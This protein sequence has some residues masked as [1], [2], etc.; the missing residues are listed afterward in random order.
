MKYVAAL[1]ES[2][3]GNIDVL[4]TSCKEANIA[5]R[6]ILGS[7]E[8]SSLRLVEIVKGVGTETLG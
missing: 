5:T 6:Y 3:K 4:Y 1:C 7:S 2:L 8:A